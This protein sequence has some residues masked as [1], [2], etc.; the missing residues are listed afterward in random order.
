M[1]KSRRT[2]RDFSPTTPTNMKKLKSRKFWLT[3]ASHALSGYL[4]STGNVEAAAV[5]SGLAQGSYN[6]GQGI[7]DAKAPE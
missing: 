7:A 6:I 3:I 1:A 4:A 2:K 5:L